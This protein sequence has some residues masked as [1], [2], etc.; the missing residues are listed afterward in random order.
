M[1]IYFDIGIQ[2]NT[3]V[4][5][6]LKQRQSGQVHLLCDFNVTLNIAQTF[7]TATFWNTIIPSYNCQTALLFGDLI[8]FG[9]SKILTLMV[10]TKKGGHILRMYWWKKWVTNELCWMDWMGRTIPDNKKVDARLLGC[11][12]IWNWRW[13]GGHE[14]WGCHRK[15]QEWGSEWNLG[16]EVAR[17]NEEEKEAKLSP[18]GGCLRR[19]QAWPRHWS[20]AHTV[21][22]HWPRR[23]QSP[24][25]PPAPSPATSSLLAANGLGLFRLAHCLPPHVG[26]EVGGEERKRRM[27]GEEKRDMKTKRCLIRMGEGWDWRQGQ[28]WWPGQQWRWW[29]G[30]SKW[31]DR[32][33]NF[34]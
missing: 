4:L 16:G 7:R 26:W 2:E 34:H 15:G 25:W 22:S 19:G 5:N 10:M 17:R 27:C 9:F 30:G 12:T 33:L 24:R 20:Q 29:W 28:I 6:H 8:T 23:L 1:W 21:A 31:L 14:N 3:L 18:R 13:G 32:G 11:G